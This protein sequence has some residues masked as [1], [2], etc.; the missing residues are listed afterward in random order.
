MES[1]EEEDESK[2]CKSARVE[3]WWEKDDGRVVEEKTVG[4]RRED[5]LVSDWV[6]CQEDEED[7]KSDVSVSKGLGFHCASP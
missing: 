3:D 4:V 7:K 6:V 2:A 5:P 1:E